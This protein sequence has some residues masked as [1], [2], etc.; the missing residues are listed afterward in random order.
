M[1]KG[2]RWFDGR[3]TFRMFRVGL[4]VQGLFFARGGGSA[5]SFVGNTKSR[6]GR[7]ET[8]LKKG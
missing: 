7:R 2:G 6:E 5:R 4:W 8:V 1:F 3:R